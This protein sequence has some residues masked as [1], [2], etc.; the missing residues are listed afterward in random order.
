MAKSLYSTTRLTRCLVALLSLLLLLPSLARADDPGFGPWA[1]TREADLRLLSATTAIPAGTGPL[2]A[3][4]EFRLKDDW[5]VYWRSPGD[6]GY[7]PS[8]DWQG[9]ENLQQ[10]STAWPVPHRFELFGIQTAGYKH[11][12]IF[13]LTLG[14]TDPTQPLRLRGAVDYLI[15][16]DICVPGHAEVS[17]DL[18]VAAG[19]A[20]NGAAFVSAA[21]HEIDQFQA[22]VP[23]AGTGISLTQAVIEPTA[24]QSFQLAVTITAEPALGED[25]DLFAEGDIPDLGHG[26]I[27]GK[28][29]VSRSADGRQAVI[30]VPLMAGFSVGQALTLTVADGVRGLETPISPAVGTG[31]TGSFSGAEAAPPVLWTMLALALLGGFILNLMPCVL[32][33]LSLKVLALVGHGGRERTEAR[34]AFIASAVGIIAA[35]L[36][37]AG[38]LIALRAGGVAIGWGIQFQQPAFLL[39]MIAVLL[40]FAANMAGLFEIRLPGAVNAIAGSTPRHGLFGHFLTG[41]FATVLAT[42]CSAPLLGTAVGFAL[43]ADG[44]T[45]VL[46]FAAL[47]LGM[48]SPYLLIAAFPGIATRLP[49]PGR[50]MLTLKKILALALLGTAL[51]LGAVLWGQLAPENNDDSGYSQ[52]GRFIPDGN[53]PP[54]AIAAALTAGKV[55]V[56]DVT[57]DWCITCKVNKAAVLDR[58]PVRALLAQ[59][60]VVALRADWTRPND[61]IAAYLASFGRYGIPFNVVYGPSAPQGIPLSELLSSD[62]V[63]TAVEQAR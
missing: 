56:V 23:Q 27:S 32:P 2:R 54:Q 43:A 26:L 46:I 22:R 6:A 8:V 30:R 42:P 39:V 12:V 60:N 11:R 48:A 5:K 21:A 63:I 47:G 31:T 16:A 25:L 40:L 3:G 24:A 58:D 13:P 59:P 14:L 49:R 35:F 10:V 29:T 50:W 38:I 37:L 33:V 44:P 52:W 7:P 53:S 45:I 28:P 9:S 61:H 18:P 17:L 41:A 36:A 55:V 51:W 15:C 4:L 57:A 1:Q 20:T 34:R 62:A 19:G